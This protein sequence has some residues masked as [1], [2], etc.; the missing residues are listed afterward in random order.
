[1]VA[2]Y[3]Q[4]LINPV[5]IMRQHQAFGL[6]MA[7]KE[8]A[9]AESAAQEAR[10]A[11]MQPL[12]IQSAE[13]GLQ[14]QRT[15]NAASQ[16]GLEQNRKA[17]LRRDQFQ[18]AMGN[19]VDLGP[20]ATV[21]DFSAVATQFP[22]YGQQVL[23]DYEAM[24]DARKNSV[25]SVL[26]QATFALRNG[27]TQTGVNLIR[28]YA[29]A[30]EAS[31]DAALAATA[32]S[33]L[34]IAEENPNAALAAAG[35]ALNTISPDLSERIFG[36][37]AKVQ[38]SQSVGPTI[39]VQTMTDGTTRVVDTTTSQVLSGQEAQDAIREAREGEVKNQRDINA[40]RSG[41]KLEGQLDLAATVAAAKSGG[42]E[43]G[44][45]AQQVA[46]DTFAQ[47]GTIRANIGNIDQAV[48]AL[49]A[50]ARTGQI[51][52]RVPT[53]NAATLELRNLR[54]QLGIDVI[55]SVTF[56]ALSKDELQ[57]ALDTAIPSNMQEADLRSWFLRKKE[58]QEIFLTRLDEMAR[59]L[60]RPDTTLNDW[61]EANG[62]EPVAN[63]DTQESTQRAA[64]AAAQGA[65]PSF[66]QFSPTFNG[67]N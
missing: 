59:F 39:S 8:Q 28:E 33:V 20:S 65:A 38:S 42:A 29:K 53:W 26:S 30:A 27:N 3:T 45:N 1:M 7:A 35:M 23:G 15:Q 61:L 36:G 32:N 17:A 4:G 64:A 37:G 19:L 51:E 5:D 56:G 12:Q 44:K 2:N 10:A 31:G 52:S 14:G 25:A 46:M 54:N 22:E 66:M 47:I 63:G 24:D 67:G 57:L 49:D 41:G 50:G 55:G 21:A 11:E 43:A 6:E 58:K 40:A 62:Q 16:F 34:K 18:S 48:A 13:L 9:M 60:S